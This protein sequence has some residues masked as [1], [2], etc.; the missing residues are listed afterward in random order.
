MLDAGIVS[1]QAVLEL[2]TATIPQAIRADLQ[3][4]EMF[5][6]CNGLSD[7][8]SS[9]VTQLTVIELQMYKRNT[10]GHANGLANHA[11]AEIVIVCY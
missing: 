3:D 5:A 1:L 8:C 10:D 6:S 7:G 2:G 11:G 4:S 9:F